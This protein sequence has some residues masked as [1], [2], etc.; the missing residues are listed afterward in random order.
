MK[1][2]KCESGLILANLEKG[3][4]ECAICKL[5][6]KLNKRLNKMS[7]MY[8]DAKKDKGVVE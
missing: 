5:P 6:K 4:G 3:E 8:N 7:Q 2:C 1:Y